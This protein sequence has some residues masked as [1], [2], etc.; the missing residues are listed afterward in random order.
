M[1][2]ITTSRAG[3]FLIFSAIGL[4]GAAM[5]WY[6]T[7]W[8]PWA[9]SDGVGYLVSA[10][11]LVEGIGLGLVQ[12]SGEF[13]PLVSHPPLYP[14]ILAAISSTGVG[15]IQAARWIDVAAF[16]LL[17]GGT[18]YLTARIT[19][20]LSW[21]AA[22]ALLILANPAIVLLYLSAMAEGLFLTSGILALLLLPRWHQTRDDRCFWFSAI[23]ASMSVLARYPGVVFG[24]TG[25]GFTLWA[26][27]NGD[28]RLAKSLQY[29]AVAILPAFVFVGY[30]M[31]IQGSSAPRAIIGP[32]GSEASLAALAAQFASE[33]WTWKPVPAIAAVQAVFDLPNSPVVVAG[34]ASLVGLS[35]AAVAAI[36]LGRALGGRAIGRSD[37]P[38]RIAAC[39]LIAFSLLYAAFVIASYF[40]T[41]PTLDINTRTLIPVL[42]AGLLF[43]V[44]GLGHAAGSGLPY[45]TAVRCAAAA[46]VIFAAIGYGVATADIV[47]GHHRT[48]GG[49]T[50]KAW[51]QSPSLAA[52]MRL[53]SGTALIS[54]APEAILLYANRYPYDVT[55][56]VESQTPEPGGAAF[57]CGT[58]ELE[59]IF[60]EGAYLVMFRPVGWSGPAEADGIVLPGELGIC[61]AQEVGSFADGVMYLPADH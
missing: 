51:R 30:S 52:V 32:E 50:A 42:V 29:G 33:L 13:E 44:L 12:A 34:I 14:L 19:G 1:K 4:L 10:R 25:A 26:A 61:G 37:Q 55:D 41:Y 7:T 59:R 6:G 46:F 35:A 27:V 24:L 16:A 20:G 17:V 28:R 5:V 54:N 57:G 39:S 58:T 21:G 53:P 3:Y 18:G 11:N 38:L 48:G 49:Y 2:A 45:A 56:W 22:A 15:V 47:A 36:L 9:F 60:Q 31:L 23:L 40:L 43:L 8:G